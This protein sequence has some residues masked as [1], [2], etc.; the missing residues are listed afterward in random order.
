MASVTKKVEVLLVDDHPIVRQ[1]II[2]LLDQEGDLRVCAEAEDVAGAIRQYE[3]EDPDIAVVDI[4][5][6]GR[7]GLEFIKTIRAQDPDFPMLVMSM[8]DE[9]V[10]AERSLRAGANGYIMKQD[11]SERV[12]EGI[13]AVMKGDI[14]V[15]DQVRQ[16]LLRNL[17]GRPGKVGASPM[18]RLSDRELEV[19]RLMGTGLGTRQIAEELN[20]SIK[21]IETYRAHLKEKLEISN[22]SELMRFAVQWAEDQNL[23]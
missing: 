10:Y 19:F 15:S 5:L 11:V 6:S 1:G 23:I 21:T 9:T 8:H 12:V 14:Y 2:S 3:A 13:R 16:R 7:D 20:L 22:A 18:E 17:A 4:G